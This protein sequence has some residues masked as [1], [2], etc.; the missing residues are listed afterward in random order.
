MFYVGILVNTLL[1]KIFATRLFRDFEVRIFRDTLISRFCGNFAFWVTLISRFW[2]RHNLFLCQF[3]ST[4][5]WIW[6]NLINNVQINRNATD[7]VPG[8]ET[9]SNGDEEDQN[10]TTE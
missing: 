7:Y 3:Y 1:Q 8:V 10:I 6:S 2:V 4:C 5:P 9:E